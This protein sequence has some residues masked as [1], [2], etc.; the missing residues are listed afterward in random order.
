MSPTADLTT[1]TTYQAHLFFYALLLAL[2]S[3]LNHIIQLFDSEPSLI[4]E[5]H[6]IIDESILLAH[7]CSPFRPFGA[8]FVPEYLK[9]VLASNSNYYRYA[10]IETLLVDWQNDVEEAAYL[11]EAFA[12]QRRL[13]QLTLQAAP[14]SVPNG[15]S[16][17]DIEIQLMDN[18]PGNNGCNIL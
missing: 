5:A 2:G 11:E 17:R 15:F 7:R 6:Q 16:E 18:L 9:A 8:A 12:L 13:H 1:I 14:E 10:E 3:V 4:L